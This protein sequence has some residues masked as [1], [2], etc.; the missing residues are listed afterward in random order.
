MASTPAPAPHAAHSAVDAATTPAPA[1]PLP[2]RAA[3]PAAAVLAALAAEPAAAAVTVI[4]GRAGISTA[5]A[6]QA[7]LAHEKNG[8]ATRIKG[9]R[10]GIP[11]TW[12]PADGTAEGGEADAG[13]GQEPDPAVTAETAQNVAAIAP[14]ACHRAV[15]IRRR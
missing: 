4:A 6:R 7:L 10:P 3:G 8:A 12:T 5:A 14:A 13:P 2:R 11:D 9:T 1:G 15:G